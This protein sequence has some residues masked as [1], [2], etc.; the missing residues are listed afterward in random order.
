MRW[1]DS[2]KPEDWNDHDFIKGHKNTPLLNTLCLLTLPCSVLSVHYG[3]VEYICNAGGSTVCPLFHMSLPNTFPFTLTLSI[4][5]WGLPH[6][7]N[8]V[9]GWWSRLFWECSPSSL[10]QP[11]MI[12]THKWSCG[13]EW[14]TARCC[15][16]KKSDLHTVACPLYPVHHVKKIS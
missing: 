15:T 16:G 8:H 2:G 6:G 5:Q 10:L 3:A 9:S 4:C 1:H 11:A 12:L 13:D 7:V 14:K